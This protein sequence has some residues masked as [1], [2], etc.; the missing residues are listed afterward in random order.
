M[1]KVREIVSWDNCAGPRCIYFQKKCEKGDPTTA[2]M[3]QM[4]RWS[5]NRFICVDK[6]PIKVYF[7]I[8]KFR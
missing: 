3:K 1:T 6:A 5:D 4:D 2:K 8:Q 7:M